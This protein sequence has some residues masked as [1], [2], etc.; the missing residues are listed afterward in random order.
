MLVS[1]TQL[2]DMPV[3]S[4]QT[5]KELARTHTAIINPLNLTVIAY[6]VTGKTLDYDPSYL[7]I[8][9]IREIS[10]I[11]IIINDSGEFIG[12]DDIVSDK[13]IYEM[14]FELHNKHVIDEHKKKVGKV[15]D[16]IIDIDSF[17]IQQLLVQRPLL[18]SFKDNELLVRR[19]QIIEV[20]DDLIVIQSG[21]HR[22]SAKL[23]K[24]KR[25]TNPFR[26]STPQPETIKIK[27]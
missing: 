20:T 12:E 24:D 21:K 27:D 2:I 8:A 19:S 26:Q 16:Y 10:N 22:D 14:E 15:S 3:M 9:D 25:Y 7:R 4:L 23:K 5:G 11:G 17:V 1:G 6:L 18:Q 13:K